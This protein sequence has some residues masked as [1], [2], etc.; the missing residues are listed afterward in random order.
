MSGGAARC[1]LADSA[2]CAAQGGYSDRQ[3]AREPE[4][5]TDEEAADDQREFDAYVEGRLR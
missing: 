1:Y 3:L 5:A 2:G 4:W